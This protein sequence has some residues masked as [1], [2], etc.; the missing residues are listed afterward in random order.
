MQN[1]TTPK[2][3]E[4]QR[5]ALSESE[6]K[7]SVPQAESYKDQATADKIVEVAPV[8]PGKDSAIKGIDPKGSK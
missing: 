7:A 5:E 4:Q 6:K 3:A 2:S 1:P 8:E